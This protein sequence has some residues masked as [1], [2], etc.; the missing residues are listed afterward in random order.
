MEVLIQS[1][2]HP[3]FAGQIGERSRLQAGSRHSF[4]AVLH[5]E[6]NSLEDDGQVHYGYDSLVYAFFLI[7]LLVDFNQSL[8]NI[9][10]LK[11]LF[12]CRPKYIIWR[13]VTVIR[14]EK[15]GLK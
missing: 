3:L 7:L 15:L 11:I 13:L 8:L 6:L 1:F 5:A 10:Y 2:Y 9:D 4:V 12:L 14:K